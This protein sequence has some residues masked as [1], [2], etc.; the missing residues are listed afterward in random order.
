MLFHFLLSPLYFV[1][2][3]LIKSSSLSFLISVGVKFLGCGGRGG[4][5]SLS[6]QMQLQLT[7]YLSM[8]FDKMLCFR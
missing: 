4:V 8:S 2:N 3:F 1:L 5:K 7:W 6:H